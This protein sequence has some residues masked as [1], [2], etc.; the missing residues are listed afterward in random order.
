[1][2]PKLYSMVKIPKGTGRVVETFAGC[3]IMR[4]Y[5]VGDYTIYLNDKWEYAK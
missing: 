5:N 4:I 1:M 2:T 3:F